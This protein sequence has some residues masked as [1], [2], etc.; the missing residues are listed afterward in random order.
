MAYDGATFSQGF[1]AP[2][3]GK[4]VQRWQRVGSFE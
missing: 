4:E 2:K 1:H 3:V